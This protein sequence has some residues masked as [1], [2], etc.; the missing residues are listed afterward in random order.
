MRSSGLGAYLG[1]LGICPPEHEGC[2]W[3]FLDRSRNG[4]RRWC[5]MEFCGAQAKARRL[6]E[7]RRADRASTEDSDSGSR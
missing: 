3:L 4:S 2:G 5:T 7:R 6:T 1:R